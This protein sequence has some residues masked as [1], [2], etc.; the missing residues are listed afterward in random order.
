MVHFDNAGVQVKANSTLPL[1]GDVS[2]LGSVNKDGTYSFNAKAPKVNVLG[3]TLTDV[4]VTLSNTG[5]QV[6]ANSTLPLVGEVSFAGVWGKDGTY[7]LNAKAPKVN[8]LG[9]KLI[10]VDVTLSSSGVQVKA[11]S[12]LPL[13]GDVSFA[14]S[15]NKDGS[16][17]LN[18]K[19]PKVDVLGF[20]LTDVDA[21]LSSSGVQVKANSKLPLVGD[22][23]FAGSWG[24]DGSYSL[25]AKAP[26]VNVLGFTLTDVDATL[27]SNGV[28]L[29]ANSKLPL[30]GEVSFAGSWGKDGNYSLNA[31][32]PK[33]SILSFTLTDVDVTLSNASMQVKA[34]SKLALVG[35][36]SFVGVWGKDGNYS[37]NAK[38]PKVDVLGF[39]LTDV[40]ATL[41]S[42]GVQVKANSKLPLV[43]EVSFAGVWGKDGSYSLNAKAPKVDVFGFILTD[44]DATLSNTGVQVKAN[45]KLPLVGEVSFT[46]SWGKDGSYSL[47]AKAPKVN[48]LGFTLTDVDATLSS[49]GMQVKANSKLPLVGD[50]SFTGSW[51]KDGNYELKASVGKF[52]VAG[53]TVENGLVTLS[54]NELSVSAR[55]NLVNIGSVT[56]VGSIS[57]NGHFSFR[58][59]ASLAVAGFPLPGAHISI[60]NN[61]LDINVCAPIPGLGNTCFDGS[62]SPN[63]RFSFQA[64]VAGPVLVGGVPLKDITV[65]LTNDSLSLGASVGINNLAY[66]RFEGWVNTHG[67]FR[68]TATVSALKLAGFSLANGT[69]TLTNRDLTL[70]AQLDIPLVAKVNVDGYFVFSTGMFSLTG[71]G[72]VSL[73][74]FPVTAGSFTLS[75]S[76]LSLTADVNVFVATV[77]V[78]GSIRSDGQFSLSGTARV[79]FA[80][81]G[82]TASFTISN[83]SVLVSADVGVPNVATVHLVGSVRSNGQFSLT[84]SAHVGFAGFGADAS[85]T[86]NNGGVSVSA[87]VNVL[88][89]GYVRMNGSVY[90]TGQF[91]FTFS[92][93]FGVKGFGG[94]GSL[95][96]NN[97]GVRAHLDVGFGILGVGAHLDGWIYSNGNFSLDA[98]AGLHLGPL[99][100][101][102]DFHL[103]NGGFSTQVH[104]GIDLTTRILGIRIGFTVTVDVSFAINTN[105]SFNASGN[106]VA[107]AYAGISLRVGVGFSLTNHEFR[108]RTHDIGF[109]LWFVSWHPFPDIVLH[110]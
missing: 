32:A 41:S 105:G 20:I 27:S 107:T 89:V 53:F 7:T 77:H 86:L 82:G 66:A 36:V 24:K 94:S 26:K 4:D 29:K 106:V 12:T 92:G 97:S 103:N 75:N 63:G 108:I 99:N 73:A 45:S 98:H 8:V 13:V 30:V 74:G 56:F 110:Y 15:V 40:D 55:A 104:A 23:S 57:A 87:S 49:S 109:R 83:N 1:V 42:S 43:G 39:I 6:K 95:T 21:T 18:A 81:F 91:S 2:F 28:Q 31:K 93:S 96:L 54:R 72:Q 60:G 85:F 17:S 62:Y 50:V 64:T 9:F 3:F 37:L 19:A 48:V 58:A 52:N 65:G 11:N 88:W 59:T 46:G 100:G 71:T 51:A 5:V 69:L 84:G 80:G 38:A 16:Y 33:V 102:I 25:N 78:V 61:R 90:S 35:E 68:L 47:E 22:V 10:N 14:G 34:N 76:G 44:V 79:N 101:S 70:H 67:D